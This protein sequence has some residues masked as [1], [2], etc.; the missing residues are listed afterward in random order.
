MGTSLDLEVRART[1]APSN[2]QK[3]F[4]ARLASPIKSGGT[5]VLPA[6]T[7]AVL[8]LRRPESS[9]APQ[10][11]LDSLVRTDLA[12]SVPSS[13]ARVRRGTE[14]EA[15]LRAGARITAIL[16]TSVPLPHR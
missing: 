9:Q 1:C 14:G 10:V 13:N 12:V 8:H 16:G 11:R 5:I 2:G 7:T 15:C 3:R 4:T 6:G